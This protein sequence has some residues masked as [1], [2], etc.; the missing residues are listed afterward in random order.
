MP[1]PPLSRVRRPETIKMSQNKQGPLRSREEAERSQHW[2]PGGERLASVGSRLPQHAP[3]RPTVPGPSQPPGGR[4]LGPAQT[5]LQHVMPLSPE[6]AP[7][8]RSVPGLPARARDSEHRDTQMLFLSRTEAN[9]TWDSGKQ[10]CG[11][12]TVGLRPQTLARGLVQD[13]APRRAAHAGCSEQLS[14]GPAPHPDPRC[15]GLPVRDSPL[16]VLGAAGPSWPRLGHADFPVL[17]PA[18]GSL[19]CNPAE[20]AGK[21]SRDLNRGASLLLP[22]SGF[23]DRPSCCGAPSCGGAPS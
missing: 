4:Y 23:G 8:L 9:Y 7:A 11:G 17:V 22:A 14:R 2:G 19:C 18:C 5:C 12:G 1:E 3:G 16:C 21:T 15:A 20:S 6:V 13:T 10:G